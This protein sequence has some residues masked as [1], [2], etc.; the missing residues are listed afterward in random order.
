MKKLSTLSLILL[1]PA[2]VLLMAYTGGPPAGN[3]GS[4]LDGQDCTFCHGPGPAVQ[5]SNWITSNIPVTGYEPGVNYTITITVV[6]LVAEKY[7]FQITSE[8]GTAKV[9]EWVITDPTRTQLEGTA[10]VSHT[11]DGTAPVGTPNTWTMDWTAPASGTGEVGIYAAINVT[12]NNGGTSGDDIFTAG[13]M[14][15]ESTIGISE[16]LLEN[17]IAVYPNPAQNY[18]NIDLP[19]QSNI[20]VF[21]ISGREVMSLISNNVTEKIDISALHNGVYYLRIIHE[22]QTASSSFIKR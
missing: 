5:A 13:L 11:A 17:R 1:L 22:G 18:I 12:N 14:V 20:Q 6:E 10:F 7:G 19:E 16:N 21:D 8:T 9:G 4:P 2:A 3:T 15:A